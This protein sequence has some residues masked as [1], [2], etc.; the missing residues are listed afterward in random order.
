MKS[1]RHHIISTSVRGALHKAK[2]LPCQDYYCTKCSGN[3]I[4]AIVSDGAGSAKYGK[5]GAKTVC[6]TLCDILIN[7][8][9]KNIRKNVVKAINIAREKLIFHRCNHCK[10]EEELINFSATV[11][12]TFYCNGQGIFFH[13]GDGAGIAFSQGKYKDFIISE[14][15][16]GAYSCETYFYTMPDW[17]SSLRF[18][19]YKD[20]NR[21]VLMTDGITGFVFAQNTNKIRQNFLIPIAEYLDNEKNTKKAVNAL[22]NTLDDYKAQHLNPD[23]KTILWIQLP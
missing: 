6:E 18:T 7:S 5:I 9:L 14:P 4:V 1:K 12:G 11:V 10:T 22:Y 19:S 13:I 3:K 21:I 15:E 8:N 16:N 17:K 23:D 20:V 2:N